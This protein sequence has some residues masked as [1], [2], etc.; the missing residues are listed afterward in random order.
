MTRITHAVSITTT[1]GFCWLMAASAAAQ[2]TPDKAPAP[3]TAE[4]KVT[5]TPYGFIIGN[6]AYN[7][8]SVNDQVAPSIAK[9]GSKKGDEDLFTDG[10]VIVTPRQT[11]LGVKVSTAMNE[12]VSVNGKVE[13]DFWGLHGSKGPGAITQTTIRL[14]LAYFTIGTKQ[15]QLLVGQNWVVLNRPWPISMAHIVI[16]AFTA[17]GNLWNRL[18]QITG[19]YNHDSGFQLKVSLV[20]PH[21]SLQSG[22][23]AITQA[24]QTSPGTLSQTP[25]FQ[26][27]AQ[28]KTKFITAGV[29]GHIGQ[30]KFAITDPN[31]G[32]AVVGDEKVPTQA[33]SADLQLS[34]EGF[35]VYVQGFIGANT[36]PLFG[37]SSVR[38]ITLD[39]GTM[40]TE[41]VKSAGGWVELS[42]KAGDIKFY[43]GAGAEKID[44]DDAGTENPASTIEN[45]MFYV[46]I[47]YAPHKNFDVG[48]EYSRNNTYYRGG[49]TANDGLNDHINLALRMKF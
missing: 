46:T 3:P 16:P 36:K 17:G 34:Y 32:D 35:A 10:S 40:S 48:L 25:F 23:G 20:H 12:T 1:V 37:L 39:D 22:S 19:I 27:R 29:S 13:V 15:M 14:R 43:A 38:K 2:G 31:N 26:G 4:S 8:G 49:G 7:T 30:E 33:V 42:Y 9:S 45:N 5:I 6:L 18:P 44:D 11:R 24:I 21:D 47:M 28:F 41:E